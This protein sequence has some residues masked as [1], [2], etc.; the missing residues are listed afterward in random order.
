MSDLTT[1]LPC[2]PWC[3]LRAGHMVHEFVVA[4]AR[5][6]RQALTC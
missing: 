2:P 3:I 5:V 6:N 1:T 4:V